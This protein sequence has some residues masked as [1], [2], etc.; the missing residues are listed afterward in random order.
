MEALAVN[1]GNFAQVPLSAFHYLS[2]PQLMV[3]GFVVGYADGRTGEFIWSQQRMAKVLGL[4]ESTVRRAEAELEEGGW[5]SR[6]KDSRQSGLT[7]DDP[8]PWKWR[9]KYP[10]EENGKTSGKSETGASEKTSGKSEKPSAAPSDS[11][12]KERKTER[13]EG[14]YRG[15]HNQNREHERAR[16]VEQPSVR[17]S[18]GL[19]GSELPIRH[20]EIGTMRGTCNGCG[21]EAWL[22]PTNSRLRCK[23]CSRPAE[24]RRR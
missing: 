10:R 6:I 22:Y 19:N 23:S 4:A 5:I 21:K 14:H 18:D 9:D 24:R 8:K 12:R 16:E 1:R 2:A 15:D 20:N 7:W 3:Y 11:A 17:V 13:R